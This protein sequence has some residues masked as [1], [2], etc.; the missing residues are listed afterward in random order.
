MQTI[1]CDICKKKVEDSFTGRTFFYYGTHNVCEPCKE[2][3]EN[4][5]RAT[6]RTKEPFT[7]E[8]YDKLMCDTFAKNASKSK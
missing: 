4:Q 8:W 2:V 1:T 5:V 6:I 7:Y 3:M